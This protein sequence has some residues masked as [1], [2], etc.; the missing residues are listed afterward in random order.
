MQVTSSLPQA[1]SRSRPL[2]WPCTHDKKCFTA[3]CAPNIGAFA[4][5]RL[6]VVAEHCHDLHAGWRDTCGGSCQDCEE[7]GRTLSGA[8]QIQIPVRH[9]LA[10]G[11]AARGARRSLSL[12]L[13]AVILLI[14]DPLST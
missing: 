1:L 9:V 4:M 2:E 6:K 5:Q 7:G 14:T 13:L 12:L 10:M 3:D 11:T 8:T